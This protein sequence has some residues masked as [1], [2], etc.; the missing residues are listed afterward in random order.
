MGGRH[1]PNP[2]GGSRFRLTLARVPVLGMMIREEGGG[3]GRHSLT[4]GGGPHRHWGPR[5]ATP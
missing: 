1:S 2:G 3:E 4:P 5:R